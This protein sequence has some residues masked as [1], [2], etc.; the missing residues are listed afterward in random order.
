M[1][2]ITTIEEV[3]AGGYTVRVGRTGDG[4]GYEAVV[5]DEDG[6]SDTPTKSLFGTPFAPVDF[7]IDTDDAEP[8]TAPTV[9]A[10]HRWV[11]IGLAIEAYEWG[12]IDEAPLDPEAVYKWSTI[13]D[14]RVAEVVADLDWQQYGPDGGTDE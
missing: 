8:V 9:T 5:L 2:D 4:E 12:E 3:S 1:T 14:E 7:N 11:A 10:P 6:G 13:D